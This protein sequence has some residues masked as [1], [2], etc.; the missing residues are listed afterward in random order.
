ML[1]HCHACTLTVCPSWTSTSSNTVYT[2]F[3]VMGRRALQGNISICHRENGILENLAYKKQLKEKR[4]I[5][6]RRRNGGKTHQRGSALLKGK[7]VNDCRCFPE[8]KL[9]WQVESF[10]SIWLLGIYFIHNLMLFLLYLIKIC[11]NSELYIAVT[12]YLNHML[13]ILLL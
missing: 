4:S 12:F 9:K 7:D 13:R 8:I 6:K 11:P 3:H 1:I 5:M 2:E 10:H